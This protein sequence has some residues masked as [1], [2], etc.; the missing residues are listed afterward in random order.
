MEVTESK[1]P[2]GQQ[3]NHE[4]TVFVVLNGKAGALLGQDDSHESLAASF[5][6]H[7]ITAHLIPQDSG[8]LPERIRHARDSGATRVIV[9][10]GDGTVACAATLLAET[11]IALGIIP[12]GTMN[13]LA[14]DL[15]LPIGDPQ[16]AVAHLANGEARLIDAGEVNGHLFL[17]ASMLGTPA[18]LS[19]H[20]EA[21]R[22]RGNGLLAWSS[23]AQ[24]SFRALRRNT[25]L[26]VTLRCNGDTIR[27]RSPSITITINKLDDEGGH[28]FS[29][30]CLDGGTLAIYVVRP[31][32]PWRHLAFLLRTMF[33][34]TIKVPEVLV[35]HT[36]QAEIQTRSRA[37]HVLVDGELRLLEPPLRYTVRHQTLRVIAPGPSAENR[38]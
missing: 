18:K 14:K 10:G 15:L 37:L 16:Q 34:G 4:E 21:G 17:C 23:F 19:R 22:Q 2:T 12:C 6:E 35:I 30:S 36:D 3:E 28:L 1:P 26:R 31:N 8:S 38:N 5:K 29:R 25:N 27:L 20:R 11:D 24:A 7:G 13:L 9:A 32:P 33:T